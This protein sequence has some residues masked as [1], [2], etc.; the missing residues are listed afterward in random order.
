M[1]CIWRPH[2]PHEGQRARHNGEDEHR[3]R[4]PD[5]DPRHVRVAQS[6]EAVKSF[7][8]RAKSAAERY[9]EPGHGEP[10]KCAFWERVARAVEQNL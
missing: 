1:I 2:N 8:R 9:L 7:R 10:S 3:T 4:C 5:K 6:R